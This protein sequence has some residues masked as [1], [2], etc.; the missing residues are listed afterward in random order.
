[1]VLVISCH[2]DTGFDSHRLRRGKGGVFHGHLDNFAGVYAVMSAYFSGRMNRRNVRI[3]LTEGE[4]T[5]FAGARRVLGSLEPDDVVMVVDVTGVV[6]ERDFTIEKC[7]DGL[8]QRFLRRTL[9]GMQFDLFEDCPDP[10]ADEDETDVYRKR[11]SAVCFL[12]IPCTGGD[13]NEGPVSCRLRSVKAV[14]E[15]VCRIAAAFPSIGKL[16]GRGRKVAAAGRTVRPRRGSNLLRPPAGSPN[17]I[18]PRDAP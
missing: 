12:G 3:E 4:E 8:L 6:T 9:R 5:D 18:A 15:A 2:A 16:Q 13:Y 14:C 10:I 7:S 17:G 11:C 1:M